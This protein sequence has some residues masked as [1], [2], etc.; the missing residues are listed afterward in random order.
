M[1]PG[2]SVPTE[3]IFSFH[4]S[5]CRAALIEIYWCNLL[6]IRLL[7]SGRT[8][9]FSSLLYLRGIAVVFAKI[10]GEFGFL[11]STLRIFVAK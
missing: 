8:L 4:R 9:V 7:S 3:V 10:S 1:L 5:K 2:S 6:A 11:F